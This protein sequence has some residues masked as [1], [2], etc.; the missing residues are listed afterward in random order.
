MLCS[1]CWKLVI[2]VLGQCVSLIFEGQAVQ[3]DGTDMLLQNIN[4]QLATSQFNIPEEWRKPEIL[5]IL[6]KLPNLKMWT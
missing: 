6:V 2:V 5:Q 1:V 4:S 3:E